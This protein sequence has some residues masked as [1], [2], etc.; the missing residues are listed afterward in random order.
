M[1]MGEVGCKKGKR[2]RRVSQEMRIM[3]FVCY[4]WMD[5]FIGEGSSCTELCV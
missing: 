1:K 4:V 5:G 2:G 3:Q